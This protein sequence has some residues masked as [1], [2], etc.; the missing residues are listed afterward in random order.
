MPT[1]L[2]LVC[3][4]IEAVGSAVL[5][6][7]TR[8]VSGEQLSSDWVPFNSLAKI[9]ESVNEFTNVPTVYFVLPTQSDWTVLWNN[10]FLCDGYDSLCWCLTTNYGMTTVHWQSSN[11]DAVFQAGSLF[12]ARRQ[13]ASGLVERSV[14]CCKDDAH[15]EFHALGEPLPEE[16]IAA[17]SARRA[18]DRLNEQG[19][20]A[21]LSR[22]GAQ[23][24]EDSFYRE[25][26]A[27]RIERI[28][29]PNTISRKTFRDFA[30]KKA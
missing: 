28:S 7:V 16:E 2:D 17:Y 15:W 11:E 20:M 6:E 26:K 5:T 3:A 10:S 22:L 1:S 21:L 29:L 23:P 24:W 12:T 27:F 25:G 19:L 30:R 4:L 9:F 18:R 13:S 8:F 14:Y